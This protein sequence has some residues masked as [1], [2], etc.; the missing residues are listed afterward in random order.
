[1]EPEQWYQ[2]APEPELELL[3]DRRELQS[4]SQS[5]CIFVPAP[6]PRFQGLII[7]EISLMQELTTFP[8]VAGQKHALQGMVGHTNFP[9][10]IPFP[11]LFM[12]LKLGNLC[13]YN[14]ITS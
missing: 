7:F 2:G 4:W 13:I 8:L 10:T 6:K 3:C 14:K 11:L 5:S 1:M 12:L 9:P